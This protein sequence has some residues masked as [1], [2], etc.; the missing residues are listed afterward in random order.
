MQKNGN[1][2]AT[3]THKS[4]I[5]VWKFDLNDRKEEKYLMSTINLKPVSVNVVRWSP[6][7]EILAI[8]GD[9][10]YVGLFTCISSSQSPITNRKSFLSNQNIQKNMQ[11]MNDLMEE[12]WRVKLKLYGHSSIVCD[13][14]WCPNAMSNQFNVDNSTMYIASASYDNT[15][16]IWECTS[17]QLVK[18]I[19]H[20]E[21]FVKGIS[22]DPTGE[23][24]ASQSD[25]LTLRIYSLK[26]DKEVVN[27]KEYFK[28]TPINNSQSLRL[29]WCPDGCK[30]VAGNVCTKNG[31]G[32]LAV[33]VD[34]NNNWTC[35]LRGIR[36]AKKKGGITTARFCHGKMKTEE[37]INGNDDINIK[38]S[39]GCH[40]C[41][42]WATGGASGLVTI[43]REMV[44]DGSENE[45][46]E[47]DEMM[48][49]GSVEL[50]SSTV[51]DIT[52]M[53]DNLSVIVV[54]VTGECYMISLPELKNKSK[55]Y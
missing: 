10:G 19:S 54:V 9:N 13:L 11:N 46:K 42:Y 3:A 20:H 45:G 38:K 23:Y 4:M 27:I 50:C 6:M 15:I 22:W 36:G 47:R 40:W 43:W 34:R 26:E 52:W 44:R 32:H 2:L 33:V 5:Y 53:R 31:N 25:D 48:Y 49:V 30:L 14:S 18:R 8:A 24:I 1:R 55:T 17:G 28:N 39:N 7:K 51:C 29:D 16:C 21:S 37:D 35:E 41:W 12:Q